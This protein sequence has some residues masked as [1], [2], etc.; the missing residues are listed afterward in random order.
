[1]ESMYLL[2]ELDQLRRQRRFREA[3]NRTLVVLRDNSQAAAAR[4][5]AL[6]AAGKVEF[7]HGCYSHAYRSF[8][9]SIQ[10][11]LTIPHDSGSVSRGD[12]SQF[13]MDWLYALANWARYRSDCPNL[14]ELPIPGDP[15]IAE[16]HRRVI[17]FDNNSTSGWSPPDAG[18][19]KDVV[20]ELWVAGCQYHRR[21]LH[22]DLCSSTIQAAITY[23][24]GATAKL[25]GEASSSTQS[26]RTTLA[27]H[28][29]LLGSVL[30]SQDLA[31][32]AS[33]LAF[34]LG[35]LQRSSELLELSSVDPNFGG[36]VASGLRKL[37]LGTMQAADMSALR[38]DIEKLK[39]SIGEGFEVEDWA[40]SAYRR[41]LGSHVIPD[42]S[43]PVL[44][45]ASQPLLS[46]ARHLAYSYHRVDP[47]RAYEITKEA[48]KDFNSYHDRYQTGTNPRH[49]YARIRYLTKGCSSRNRDHR[50][51]IGDEMKQLL[52]SNELLPE[53]STDTEPDEAWLPPA[54][55]QLRGLPLGPG[56]LISK[57]YGTER[58]LL[59]IADTLMALNENSLA[60][61]WYRGICS[62][63]PRSSLAMSRLVSTLAGAG[64]YAEAEQE[65]SKLVCQ[66]GG[67]AC[68]VDPTQTTPDRSTGAHL[69][70]I[71]RAR[72]AMFKGDYCVAEQMFEA[73]T[74]DYRPA[75]ATAGWVGL[76]D[77]ARR[78]RDINLVKELAT[79]A[80][81]DSRFDDFALRC[82]IHVAHAWAEMQLGSPRM[83]LRLL[84]CALRHLPYSISGWVAVVRSLRILG[85]HRQ[86]LEIL[87]RLHGSP[88]RID[89]K[90]WDQPDGGHANI[91]VPD[92]SVRHSARLLSEQGWV[93]LDLDQTAMAREL[94]DRSVRQ[95][96]ELETALRGYIA[97]ATT[98]N[99]VLKA[100]QKCLGW[101]EDSNRKGHY[102]RFALR[103][104]AGVR[105]MALGQYGDAEAEFR[106]IRNWMWAA[107]TVTGLRRRYLFVMADAYLEC[108]R[109]PEAAEMLRQIS[110]LPAP[111]SNQCFPGDDRYTLFKAR[112]LLASGQTNKAS[113]VVKDRQDELGTAC[114]PRAPHHRRLR[115]RLLTRRHNPT[116][117]GVPPVVG[118][119]LRIARVVAAYESRNFQQAEMW[120]DHVGIAPD[121][122]PNVALNLRDTELV[123]DL[124]ESE[125]KLLLQAWVYLAISELPG[126]SPS[127]I[128]ALLKAATDKLAKSD[129][130]SVDEFHLAGI[131]QARL[132]LHA[133]TEG[134]IVSARSYLAKA[135]DRRPRDG[136]LWRDLG[137]VE[138]SAGNFYRALD[139]LGR[140]CDLAPHDARVQLLTGAVHYALASPERAVEHFRQAVALDP[141]DYVHHRALV[142]TLLDLDRSE[143]ALRAVSKGVAQTHPHQ[144][145][146]LRLLMTRVMILRTK[147]MSRQNRAAEIR[148]A[149]RLLKTH[150]GE[151]NTDVERSEIQTRIGFCRAVQGARWRARRHAKRAHRLN[152]AA[153]EPQRLRDLTRRHWRTPA[154]DI[155]PSLRIVKWAAWVVLGA[156]VSFAG[157][158]SYRFYEAPEPAQDMVVGLVA[159]GL[160]LAPVA[161]G[162]T[163][164]PRFK[165]LWV[166]TASIELEPPTPLT[167]TIHIDL[168]LSASDL[169][170]VSGF[171][172]FRPSV[173]YDDVE[174][175][176]V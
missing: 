65:I 33:A 165:I 44:I 115:R 97:S 116:S 146:R 59:T 154:E 132:S 61:D 98:P 3:Y 14:E 159:S 160:W 88:P 162:L 63:F 19:D 140:A 18:A 172:N 119:P 118:E 13:D 20:G 10:I 82:E 78:R 105:L 7:E 151:A 48:D 55:E 123:Q 149:I 155:P 51:L 156:V 148:A 144:K 174:P 125:I 84:I 96:V 122:S 147:E 21:Q 135:V 15:D 106:E 108:R 30:L 134:S 6:T 4:I 150:M 127:R 28:D 16:W 49:S 64:Q 43:Q 66:L 102:E 136:T 173:P 143:E 26:C 95:T 93:R 99:E 76:L 167:E 169:M 130:L 35:D 107:P 9:K 34:E 139:C 69:L 85:N 145:M 153:P 40:I 36:H 90:W 158:Q 50:V 56:S 81:N 86:A 91:S 12:T 109:I 77:V 67:T 131:I 68:Q 29:R 22:G 170:R 157:Y 23:L 175:R 141:H 94:F 71:E 121:P 103:L 42:V 27:R 104:E 70:N 53:T 111:D 37:D 52:A 74:T 176:V 75:T 25:N 47:M 128:T 89:L 31:Y 72:I 73:L 57:R 92:I 62:V 126:Q 54:F 171:S 1:M 46:I 87:D 142:A 152:P 101:L 117:P 164:L 129:G 58:A 11:A 120:T 45:R 110:D 112:L 79:R 60:L 32:Q 100:K 38:S 24:D 124:P 39:E 17:G 163:L 133:A 114:K 5:V 2:A 41:T 161:I 166:G 137:A 113:E 83:A 168:D 8:A 138:W 80:H